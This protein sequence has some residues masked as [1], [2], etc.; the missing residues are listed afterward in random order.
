VKRLFSLWPVLSVLLPV[1]ALAQ[2]ASALNTIS[3]VTVKS[4]VVEITGTQKPSFSTFPMTDPPRLV[5][6]ISQAVFSGVPEAIDVTSGHVVAIKT[7]SY[8]SNASA[9]ARVVI[10]FDRD[11]EPD[12][13]AV[14]N[15][16][17]VRSAPAP[18]G[19]A[20]VAAAA[21]AAAAA[22]PAA[23]LSDTSAAT[24][25]SQDAAASAQAAAAVAE[26]QR[27]DAASAA[28]AEKQRQDA[29]AVAATEQQRKDAAAA[30]ASE[31]QRQDAATA[32]AAV[33]EKQRQDAAAAAAA[34]AEKQRLDAAAAVAAAEDKRRHED[35][36]A[37]AAAEEK[38]RQE[39][40]VAAAAEEKRQKDEVA[41]TRTREEKQQAAAAAAAAEEKRKQESALAAAAAENQRKQEAAATAAAAEQRRRQDG[42]AAAAVE[43]SRQ[44]E[45]AAGAEQRRKE[46]TKLASAAEARGR[47]D[48]LVVAPKTQ[49]APGAGKRPAPAATE[50]VNI[51]GA[52][53]AGGTEA[54]SKRKALT[55]VGFDE[56]GPRV[57]VRT[58]GPVRYSVSTGAKNTV[59][60]ELDNTSIPLHNNSR[61]LDTA[62]FAGP[63]LRIQPERGPKN[64][65]RVAIT[66]RDGVAYQAHQDGNEVSV[67]FRAP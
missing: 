46:D 62:F 41:S 15:K 4:G 65:V 37:A 49:A 23:K 21:P 51:E 22:S 24:A 28:A 53:S 5:V 7:A 64:S 42:A 50:S 2:D 58:N 54:N 12:I 18:G 48:L 1:A 16:L 55:F 19:G 34:A 30:A 59:V 33:A 31:K 44:S 10:G 26:K 47:Q 36:A 8:G 43:Q 14:G 60:V 57:Y 17:V 63:V 45:A 27:Q 3:R 32:A 13:Q 29:A 25:P 6:D 35:A 38:R 11:V 39:A 61:A 67:Q 56:K 40:A 66:L 20:A 52:G 9:I